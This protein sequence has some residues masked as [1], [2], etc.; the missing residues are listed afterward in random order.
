VKWPNDVLVDGRKVCGILAESTGTAVIVG[1]GVNTAMTE[2]QLPVPMATS[3]AALGATADDD[4]LVAAYVRG[5]D[6]LVSSLTTWGDAERSG[7]HAAV[8]AQCATLGRE[9]DV[10]L[11]DGTVLHGTALSLEPDGRLCVRSDGTLHLVAAGDVVHA[12]LS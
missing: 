11:P 3:F 9:V 5:V 8:S 10:S 1:A 4:L 12:R 7:V 2:E 6:D